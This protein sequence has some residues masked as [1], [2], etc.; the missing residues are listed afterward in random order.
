MLVEAACL[1]VNDHESLSNN[2]IVLRLPSKL[3]TLCVKE[4]RGEYYFWYSYENMIVK[5]YISL[6]LIMES[7]QK[8]ILF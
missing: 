5:R 8:K 3:K 1:D 2:L 7:W 4:H 6:I